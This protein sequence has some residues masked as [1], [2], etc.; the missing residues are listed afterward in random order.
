MFINNYKSVYLEGGGFYWE[1]AEQLIQ[2]E[3]CESMLKHTG[4]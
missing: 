3:I 1:K 2:A 4:R